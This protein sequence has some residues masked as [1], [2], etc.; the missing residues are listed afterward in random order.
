MGRAAPRSDDARR[1]RIADPSTATLRK[2][3]VRRATER[4]ESAQASCACS[5]YSRD[6]RGPRF[7]TRNHEEG[8]DMPEAK[9]V[10][11]ARKA[12]RQG[13]APTTAAGAFV[14]EEIEHIRQGLHGAR[15]PKQAIA[16]GLSKARR[17]GI[18]LGTP[19]RGSVSARTRRQA[20]RDEEKGQSTRRRSTSP[21]RS[22]AAS[23]AL[24]RE[25]RSAGSRRALSAQARSAS[26][27]GRKPS[28]QARRSQTST[29]GGR[30]RAGGAKRRTNRSGRARAT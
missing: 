24:K 12:Q 17:A 13:K 7:A 2:S 22:R 15:S 4:A 6:E 23:N 11:R 18:K 16:I 27:R 20:A 29:R 5:E 1:A 21:R 9:T 3:H 8:F 30:R 28:T 14:R 26:R 25:G 19:K 10:G